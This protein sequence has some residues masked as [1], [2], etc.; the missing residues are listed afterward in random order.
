MNVSLTPQL[1]NY[2]RSKV[3]SGRYNSVS[4]VVREALRLSQE[5]DAKLAHLQDL[6]QEGMKSGDPIEMDR[7]ELTQMLVDH[8]ATL[9]ER[10]A[11]TARGGA[12]T[13]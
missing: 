5:Q 8:A 4:E 3:E 1:E 6:I 11:H 13:A 9:R 7:G 10:D 2:A 12:E